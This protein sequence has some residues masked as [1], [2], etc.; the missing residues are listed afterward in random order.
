L[1]IHFVED[2]LG[3]RAVQCLCADGADNEGNQHSSLHP[4][5]GHVSE[6]DQYRPRDLSGQDLEEISTH[7]AGGTEPPADHAHASVFP[8]QHNVD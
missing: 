1:H 5:A 7:F 8:K 4:L 2:L 3:V 6:H